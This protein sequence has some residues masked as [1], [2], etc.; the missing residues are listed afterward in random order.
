MSVR[1]APKSEK[2]PRDA[3]VRRDLHRLLLAVVVDVDLGALRRVALD[4]AARRRAQ[5]FRFNQRLAVFRG[6]PFGPRVVVTMEFE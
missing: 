3:E 1:T 4:D 6:P 5:I 2:K